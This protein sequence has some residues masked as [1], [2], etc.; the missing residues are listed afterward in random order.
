MIDGYRVQIVSRAQKRL[1]ERFQAR[2]K[3]AAARHSFEV[4][5]TELDMRRLAARLQAVH[6][7]NCWCRP[8]QPRR[9][10]KGKP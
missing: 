2:T 4:W 10:R 7:K 3:P 5:A 6:M 9:G 1:L 8:L